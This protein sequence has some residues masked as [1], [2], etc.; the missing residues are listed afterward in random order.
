MI[1]KPHHHDADAH[2]RTQQSRRGDDTSEAD[3]RAGCAELAEEASHAERY[4]DDE[5]RPQHMPHD[6]VDLIPGRFTPWNAA[7]R[8]R[9]RIQK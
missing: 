1:I 4:G 5:Q 7:S 3:C 2:Q 9:M 8:L 6:E